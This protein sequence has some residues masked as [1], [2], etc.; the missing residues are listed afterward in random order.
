LLQ[1]ALQIVGGAEIAMIVVAIHRGQGLN[2]A[3]EGV[4]VQMQRLWQRVRER[5]VSFLIPWKKSE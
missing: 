5:W 1:M 3:T 4:L 2:A